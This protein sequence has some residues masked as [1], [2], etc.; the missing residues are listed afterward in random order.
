MIP[1]LP[2]APLSSPQVGSSWNF[3]GQFGDEEFRKAL[4][5][6]WSGAGGEYRAADT[7]FGFSNA[8]GGQA[9]PRPDPL[10]MQG[11]GSLFGHY[12]PYLARRRR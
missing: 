12:N 5:Q 1:S 2:A 11:G 8:G 3:L 10:P 6:A 7:P 4:G 9:M